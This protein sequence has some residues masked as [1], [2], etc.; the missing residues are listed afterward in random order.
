MQ[1][2]CLNVEVRDR[3]KQHVDLADTEEDFFSVTASWASISVDP[4]A[5]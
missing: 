1:S 3:N 4:S 5:Q 2:L